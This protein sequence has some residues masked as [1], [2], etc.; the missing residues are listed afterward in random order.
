LEEYKAAG[1]NKKLKSQVLNR[2][3]N[4]VLK[5]DPPIRFVRLESKHQ[6]WYEIEAFYIREKISQTFRDIALD[7]YRS[8]STFKNMKRRKA[9]TLGGA[10]KGSVDT[11][12]GEGVP[13]SRSVA[14]NAEIQDDPGSEG[15]D[16]AVEPAVESAEQKNSPNKRLPP[17]K[18]AARKA[19]ADNTAPSR[20]SGRN[21][22][23]NNNEKRVADPPDESIEPS[24]AS[25]LS[26]K[27][28]LA[29][30]IEE[31]QRQMKMLDEEE[32]QQARCAGDASQEDEAIQIMEASGRGDQT[33]P[34]SLATPASSYAATLE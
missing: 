5:Q 30:Q 16:S 33:G 2:V 13:G 31:L 7:G 32:K 18:T 17:K 1:N 8:A 15:E 9:S 24:L 29:R 11:T 26:K 27:E 14:D 3:A 10:R 6:R 23:D 4:F 19:A 34:N 25:K 22:A 21:A 28:D 12:N 20:K